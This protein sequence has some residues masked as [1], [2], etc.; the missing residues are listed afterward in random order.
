MFFHMSL[1]KI[2]L[3]HPMTFGKRLEEQIKEQLKLSVEGTVDPRYGYII[4]V[5]IVSSLPLGEVQE[6]GYVRFNV[7]YKA[8]VFRPFR[9]EVLDA[10]VVSIDSLGINCQATGAMK[11]FIYKEQI[12]DDI[13][14]DPEGPAFTYTDGMMQIKEGKCLRVKIT[15]IRFDPIGIVSCSFS[16]FDFLVCCWDHKGR[17][18]WPD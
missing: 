1:T 16:I 11:I 6:G 9:N 5:T 8:I 13:Q 12:P 7:S 18:S 3:M 14:Y 10:V 2:L 4:R 15:G 17:F